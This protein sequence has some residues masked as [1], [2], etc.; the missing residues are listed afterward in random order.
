MTYKKDRT[1][2]NETLEQIAESGLDVVSE[3]IEVKLGPQ[4]RVHRARG[5]VSWHRG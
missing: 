1:L 5:R 2:L 3:L 4:W